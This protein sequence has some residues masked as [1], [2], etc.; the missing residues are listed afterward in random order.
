MRQIL[1]TLIACFGLLA[2][3]AYAVL[4]QDSNHD[5]AIA[6]GSFAL[7]LLALTFACDRMATIGVT[8]L[9]TGIHFLVVGLV[10]ADIREL[11]AAAGLLMVSAIIIAL[12]RKREQ[13]AMGR[14]SADQEMQA[15]Q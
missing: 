12:S 4:W 8:C 10:A 13:V 3:S 14:T 6:V 11:G 2:A 15:A 9:F 1:A 7:F 5:L